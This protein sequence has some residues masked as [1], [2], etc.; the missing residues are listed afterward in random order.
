MLR[1]LRLGGIGLSSS[2][3]LDLLNRDDVD[4]LIFICDE[5]QKKYLND[6]YYTAR[7]FQREYLLGKISVFYFKTNIYQ[8]LLK[9][10]GRELHSSF[11]INL[12]L[13][14]LIN[15]IKN[16]CKNINAVWIGDNDFDGS[17]DLFVGLKKFFSNE[18]PIIRSYKETRFI[19]RW[20]EYITLK[21][22][23]RLIFPNCSYLDFFRDLYRIDLGGKTLF[24][25]L[26][27]RYSG[28][29]NWV[30]SI[31]VEKLSK[32][33]RTPH[34]C[35]LT[36]R[37]LSDTRETRSGYR[38][39]FISII[40]ELINR[41]IAVHLHAI[42]IEPDRYGR[43]LYEEIKSSSDLFY[44][45]NPLDLIV[46]SEDYTILK[47]YDAGFLHPKIPEFDKPLEKFQQINIP[48]RVYE[49]QMADVVPISQIGASYELEKLIEATNYGI[50]YKDYDHLA[51]NLFDLI[52][53]RNNL[54]LGKVKTYEDFADVLIKAI[55]ND[56]NKKL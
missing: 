12:S 7:Y 17:N 4:Q 26:D 19:K 1:I 50:I 38:Y 13:I 22:S 23:T 52:E 54:E 14:P 45:E 42:H 10:V 21:E 43:N 27:W 30:K 11:L 31:K 28:L 9:K 35:I 16:N 25:D 15:E 2:R 37:A 29:V 47:R 8:K 24:A 18:L 44:I 33:D 46:G 36:G 3:F 49:Y 5:N 53:K 20:E 34:V 48:N 56:Y 39:Y 41:G 6:L 51:K 40:K 55:H 32:R